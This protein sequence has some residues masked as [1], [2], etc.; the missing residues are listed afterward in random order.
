MCDGATYHTCASTLK[1]LKDLGIPVLFTG[2]HSYDASPI[3]SWFSALKAVDLN[4]RG[5]GMG[6]GNFSNVVSA[7][8]MRAR[9]IP[10]PQIMM[11]FHHC[12]AEAY[13]YLN[14]NTS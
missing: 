6:K 13:K 4:P 10:R 9:A 3:E 8:V 1:L 12:L 14:F 7:V 11:M 2:P 5:Y